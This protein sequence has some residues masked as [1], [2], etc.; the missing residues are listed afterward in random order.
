VNRGGNVG[1]GGKVLWK[2]TQSGAPI[3]AVQGG[4]QASTPSVQQITA[5][6]APQQQA[7]EPFMMFRLVYALM[8][9]FQT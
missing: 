7:T 1:K 5:I 2:G 8:D 6:L 4:N 9:H 3:E